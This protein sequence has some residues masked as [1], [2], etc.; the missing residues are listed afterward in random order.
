MAGAHFIGE[1]LTPPCFRLVKVEGY[2]AL[3]AGCERVAGEV[4]VVDAPLVA[5]LDAFEGCP[6]LYQRWTITLEDG[7]EVF[8]YGMVGGRVAG[9]PGVPGGV[10]REDTCR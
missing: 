2:P 7:R 6:E 5:R 3:A 1:A 4:F 10:W 8:A 9:C